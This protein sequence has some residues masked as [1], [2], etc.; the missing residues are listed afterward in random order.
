MDGPGI[1][2]VGWASSALLFVTIVWQ[3]RKQVREG[4]SQGVSIWLFVGNLAASIGFVMYSVAIENWVF[5]A[6]NSLMAAGNIVGMGVVI[7]QRQRGA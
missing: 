2:A 7:R 3:I 4:T 5:A 6:T 1:E